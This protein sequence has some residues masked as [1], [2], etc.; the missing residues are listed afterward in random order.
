M[1]FIKP[2]DYILTSSSDNLI[3]NNHIQSGEC[4]QEFKSHLH[5]VH[6]IQII[7]KNTIATAGGDMVKFILNFYIYFKMKAYIFL[8][9]RLLTYG[10]VEL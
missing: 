3:K 6:S 9:I 10:I 2:T 5:G 4:N 7:D 1:S 8:I